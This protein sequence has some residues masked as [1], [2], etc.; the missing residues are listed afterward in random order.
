MTSGSARPGRTHLS[1][2]WASAIGLVVP[3]IASYL[4]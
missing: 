1:P 2:Y 4:R 3:V